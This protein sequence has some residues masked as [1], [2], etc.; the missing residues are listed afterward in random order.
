MKRILLALTIVL[1][2]FLMNGG[3]ELG[4]EEHGGGYDR[5]RHVER[6]DRDMDGGGGYQERGYEGERR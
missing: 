4:E 5:D 1:S 2:A 3:C 6:S